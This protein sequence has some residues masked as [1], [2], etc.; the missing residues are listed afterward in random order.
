MSR[1]VTLLTA[2]LAALVVLPGCANPD[3]PAAGIATRETAGNAGE[4]PAPAPPP[5]ASEHPAAAQP[6]AQ[7][8]V[9]RFASLYMNW[10]Y[11]TLADEQRA[12]ASAAVGEARRDAL[13]AATAAHNPQ[14]TRNRV[15]NRGEILAMAPDR[16]RPGRWLIVTREET[17]GSAEYRALPASSH[18]IVA[19]AVAAGGGWAIEQWQPQS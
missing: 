19:L 10:T 13:Q 15:W 11:R 1:R 2:A 14:L 4:P 16:A 5:I 3:A 7:A 12:L 8:A 6:T 17:G 18:V 9:E